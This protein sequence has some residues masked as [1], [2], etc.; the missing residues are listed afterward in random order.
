MKVT[1]M[2]A[3]SREYWPLM[4]M[5]SPNKLEYALRHGVQLH[6]N[7]HHG[8]AGC[9]D[10]WGERVQFMSDSLDAYACDWLWFMG[11]DT[12]ITNMTTD[13]RK[14]CDPK[15]DLIMAVD[16]NGINNDSFLLKNSKASHDFLRRVMYR[17]DQLT[18]Q[19]AMK[20]EMEAE[21]F[22]VALVNQRLFNSY[23][24][25]EY[26]YGLQ[27]QGEWQP[28]DF[29]LHLPGMRLERRIELMREYGERI[30]R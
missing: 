8:N 5:S 4:C 16:V 6:V 26:D 25:S 20:A 9:Y 18:D 29:V 30:V 15:F 19:C 21:G 27:P 10:N 2:T 24:Y 11:A 7:V 1:L 22:E 23:I 13:I 12:L 17:R 14:L 28:G 3:A